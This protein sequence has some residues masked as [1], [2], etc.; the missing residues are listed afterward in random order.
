MALLVCC[1]SC[2]EISKDNKST[3]NNNGIVSSEML[4][5][6]IQAGDD[7]YQYVNKKWLDT[8]PI[9][10]DKSRHSWFNVLD[11]LNKEQIKDI[12]NDLASGGNSQSPIAKKISYLYNSGMDTVN[13]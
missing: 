4:T 6:D 9:P 1:A 11:E 5:I 7:F 3:Q 12:F 2:G 13:I 10:A 8:N